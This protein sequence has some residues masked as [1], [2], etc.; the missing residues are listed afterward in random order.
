M[1]GFNISEFREQFRGDGARPN[2]FSVTIND[3]KPFWEGSTG[4]S[5]FCRASQI[6][7]MTQGVVPVNYM[8][9]Q[10][11]FA[12]N[13]TYAD[14][15]VTVMN[16]ENFAH[17]SQFERWFNNMN[18][19][20]SNQRVTGATGSSLEYVSNIEVVQLSKLGAVGGVGVDNVRKYILSSAFPT[21]LSPITLDW[22]DNDTIEEYTVTFAFD[23]FTATKGEKSTTGG[24]IAAHVDVI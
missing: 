3:K 7:G 15:T 17:R 21:D 5:F 19:A 16:D 10:V 22:G 2:L 6:P 23:Y 11:K 12:G 14:W 13:K 1:P 8:G 4:F 20:T 24:Q 9:R 18:G